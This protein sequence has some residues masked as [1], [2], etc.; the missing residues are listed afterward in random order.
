[1]SDKTIDCSQLHEHCEFR[2]RYI[3][4]LEQE[5]YELRELLKLGLKYQDVEGYSG[6]KEWVTRAELLLGDLK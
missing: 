3:N 1:M 5:N 4:S 6:Q 2:E